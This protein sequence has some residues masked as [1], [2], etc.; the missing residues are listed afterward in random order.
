MILGT[1]HNQA[2]DWWSL[3]VLLYEMVVGTTPFRV[4]KKDFE[5]HDEMITFEVTHPT[6]TTFNSFHIFLISRYFSV[7]V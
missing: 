3:G 5:H 7:Y 1:G 6:S 4:R 2:V